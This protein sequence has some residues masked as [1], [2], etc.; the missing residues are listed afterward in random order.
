MLLLKDEFLDIVESN[1]QGVVIL[2]EGGCF[3]MKLKRIFVG[4][5]PSM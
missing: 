1:C 3:M 4:R 5:R 2:E